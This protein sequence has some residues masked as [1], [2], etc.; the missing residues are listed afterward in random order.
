MYAPHSLR[1]PKH[2]DLLH[3]EKANSN[4][5]LIRQASLGSSLEIWDSSWNGGRTHTSSTMDLAA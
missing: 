2:K 3:R 4:L 1:M 5:L